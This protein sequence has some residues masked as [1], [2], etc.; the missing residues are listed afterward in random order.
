[1]KCEGRGEVRR[2][3]YNFPFHVRAF[4][5]SVSENFDF[6]VEINSQKMSKALS[7]KTRVLLVNFVQKSSKVIRNFS[8]C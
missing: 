1:M 3:S 5:D 6:L 4:H 7:G 8:K 2:G